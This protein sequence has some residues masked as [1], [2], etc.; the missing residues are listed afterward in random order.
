MSTGRSREDLLKFHDYLSNKGLIPQATARA[1]KAASKQVLAILDDD[2]ASDVLALDLDF[3]MQRFSTLHGQQYNPTSL[4][5][6]ASRLRASVED[7]RA[8]T[9]NPLG[10]RPAGRT[11]APRS[12][13]ADKTMTRI[14]APK[15]AAPKASDATPTPPPQ[16]ANILPIRLRA[17]LTIQ[18]A[19]LPFDL[20]LAE[21]KKIA[22]I[23]I[24]HAATDD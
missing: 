8:Y 9:S 22:N 21:A 5:D 13:S 16:S 2:E 18:I 6:Y 11:R 19:G 4:R 14:D 24:A 3:V 23:V 20:T 10:F 15:G 17:D 12:E 1:R 7:F